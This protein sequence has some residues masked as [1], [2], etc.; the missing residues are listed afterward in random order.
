VVGVSQVQGSGE[1]VVLIRE[2]RAEEQPVHSTNRNTVLYKHYSFAYPLWLCLP[3]H[4][5]SHVK[6]FGPAHFVLLLCS[7]F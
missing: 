1:H 7:A 3:W 2:G 5:Q 6:Q 4:A